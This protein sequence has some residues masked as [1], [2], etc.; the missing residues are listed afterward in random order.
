LRKSAIRI[1]TLAIY[2]ATF[3]VVPIIMPAKA[4]TNGNGELAKNKKIQRGT[5]AS[6]PK[7]ASPRWPPP[8]DEDFDRK[9][10][11]GGGGM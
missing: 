1:L 9:N 3:V 11:G 7:P 5:A 10:T 4:A 2:G 6:D 8:M